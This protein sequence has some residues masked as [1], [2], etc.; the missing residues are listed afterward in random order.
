[1]AQRVAA[2]CLG[3]FSHQLELE[4]FVLGEGVQFELH[5]C[6]AASELRNPADA[7]DKTRSDVCTGNGLGILTILCDQ[8]PD[9]FVAVVLA[10]PI[11]LHDQR[12]APF[13]FAIGRCPSGYIS[14]AAFR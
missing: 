2:Y 8:F 14:V 1:M 3:A 12:C 5:L 9:G 7:L 11:H 6:H 13:T 4:N 10:G